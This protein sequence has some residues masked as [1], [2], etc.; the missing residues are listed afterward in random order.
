[1]ASAVEKHPLE[2]FLPGN[3]KV[4]MLGSFPPPRIRWSIDFYYP[5]LTND[6]WRI[7]GSIF[8]GD[9]DRFVD[10]PNKR[11]YKERIVAFL[12]EVGIAIYDTAEEVIRLKQNASDK[13][14]E[15]VK[16]TDVGGLLDRLPECRAIV[17]TGQK[18]T[19]TL[20]DTFSIAEP[21][22]G[23]YSLF[24]Y[25]GRELRLYRLPSSSRAYPL[26]LPKKVAPY[27]LM[28]RDLGLL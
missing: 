17:T 25:K 6:M 22:M 7:M 28:F 20:C 2:P 3:A 4:L 12:E 18:A 11:F 14:L 13:F 15:V 10:A 1:M 16:P 27:E 9:K 19:A 24:Q 8:Y 26:A 5:N 23:S 21:K